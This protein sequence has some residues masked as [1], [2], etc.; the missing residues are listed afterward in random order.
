VVKHRSAAHIYLFIHSFIIRCI[1][2]LD[3]GS[4]NM[5]LNSSIYVASND[6]TSNE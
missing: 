4:L 2:S 5:D 6:V 3:L 1:C